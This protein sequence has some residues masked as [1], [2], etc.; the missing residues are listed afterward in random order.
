[1]PD[2]TTPPPPP[3]PAPQP[4]SLR[5]RL[6]L[7]VAGVMVLFI[8]AL[9]WSRI[10]TTRAGVREEI[11]AANRVTA[12]LLERVSWIVA[13]GGP[14]AMLGFLEQ[15][16]RVR[17]NDIRLTDD[18]GTL[19]YRSPP[20]IYKQGRDAP[21]WFSALVVP[22]L[23]RQVIRMQGATLTIEAD[24]SRAILDGWDD[25]QRTAGTALVALLLTGVAVFWAVGHTLRPLGQIVAALGQLGQGDYSTRLPALPGR[26]AALIGEAVNRLAQTV[27]TNITQQV[28]ALETEHRLSQSREWAQRIEARLEAERRE[29]A[30][31]L[32]DELGQSVTAIR[33]LARSLLPRLP[34]TDPQGRE[35]ARLI[36]QQAAQLYDAMHSMIPRLTPLALGPLGLADALNDLV[37]ALRQRHPDLVLTAEL[38]P[39]PQPLPGPVALAAY[40]VAQEAINNAIK[41]SGG[42]HITLRLQ[43]ATPQSDKLCA[44]HMTLTIDDDGC[45]L[46]PPGQ[47]PARFGLTGLRERV[48]ALGGAF[49]A[50]AR[51][52][53]GSRIRAE[54][55]L[56]PP[57]PEGQ[58]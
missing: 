35:A 44:P 16:G 45:G 27:Q 51:P 9:L 21:D 8:A 40:R 14:D 17:A 58:P 23:Q 30:A 24:P 6:N 22:P 15:L 20:P 48:L 54:L 26:E 12:Q 7:I 31:E 56:S 11:V 18:S 32:H 1:M 50:Q 2:A 5:L 19:R 46:P 36:D 57:Q 41:H 37:A 29:I 52:E 38:T 43:L 3:Q 13:R 53:G 4:L 42:C 39:P 28:Q 25:L 10:E 55:P 34:D 49:E 33:A 47:R